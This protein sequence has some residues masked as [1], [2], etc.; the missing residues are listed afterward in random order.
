M[1]CVT[2][3]IGEPF[4]GILIQL[5]CIKKHKEAI[6]VN[7]FM[8]N[9]V[10]VNKHWKCLEISVGNLA[11]GCLEKGIFKV[12]CSLHLKILNFFC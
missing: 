2:A 12:P 9:Q 11:L 8:S 1:L 5:G 4:N 3:K 7:V 10:S 6:A